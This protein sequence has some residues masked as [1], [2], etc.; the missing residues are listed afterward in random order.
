MGKITFTNVTINH[1]G[2]EGI[3][4]QSNDDVDFQHVHVQNTGGAAISVSNSISIF[5]Q[6]GMP[7][8]TD[9]K[10]LA[11]LFQEL[12]S[13]PEDKKLDVVKK[14]SLFDRMGKSL[15]FA[16]KAVSLAKNVDIAWITTLLS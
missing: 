15:D 13:T 1:T 10:A 16:N 14:N 5:E 4:I 9:P 7:A 6:L 2:Q 12:Q 3:K 11:R 8:D